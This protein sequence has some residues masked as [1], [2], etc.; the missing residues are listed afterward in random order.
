MIIS[1]LSAVKGSE[2]K[3]SELL[4]ILKNGDI[5]TVSS[6]GQSACSSW[7]QYENKIFG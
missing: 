4:D 2:E 5:Q 3:H 1:L 7:V 6:Y